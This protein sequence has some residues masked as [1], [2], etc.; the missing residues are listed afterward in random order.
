MTV[1][2]SQGYV[3]AAHLP[4]HCPVGNH[5]SPGAAMFQALALETTGSHLILKLSL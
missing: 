2:V 4:G 5:K 3:A 1:S